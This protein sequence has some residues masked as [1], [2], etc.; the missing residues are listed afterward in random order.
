MLAPGMLNGGEPARYGR[1]LGYGLGLVVGRYRGFKTVS[2]YSGGDL[3][4]RNEFLRF[5]D[6]RLTVIILGNLDTLRPY[7]LARQVADVCMAAKP[8]GAAAKPPEA[9]AV[10]TEREL[11]A[12]AGTYWSLRT[13]VSWTFSVKG[14]KLRIGDAS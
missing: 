9:K 5:P 7:T 8:P 2:H 10:P 11:A 4:Y 14:D 13:G 12:W 3:G 6:Q 1:D